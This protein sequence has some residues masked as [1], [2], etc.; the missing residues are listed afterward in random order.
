MLVG[1]YFKITRP[2]VGMQLVDGT[3]TLT[4][5]PVNSIIKVLS[6]PNENGR[7][8]D[9]GLVYVLCGERTVALFAVDIESRGIEIKPPEKSRKTDKSATA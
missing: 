2:T 4:T 6:G 7:L 8:R 9:K 3:A 1:K 5:L